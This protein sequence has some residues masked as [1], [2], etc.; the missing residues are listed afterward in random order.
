MSRQPF[1]PVKQ[2]LNRMFPFR[3]VPLP[4][5]LRY[6]SVSPK[7]LNIAREPKAILFYPNIPSKRT[8]MLKICCMNGYRVRNDPTKSF[9]LAV[10]WQDRT[11]RKRDET[12]LN[13]AAKCRVLNIGCCDI[14]KEYVD[15]VFKD[16]FG[17]SA[18]IDPLV[19]EGE[20][21]VKSNLNAKHDGRIEKCPLKAV[22][23][24]V[25][26]QKLINNLCEED[27]IEEIRVPVFGEK[28]PCVYLK[29]RPREERFLVRS[30]KVDMRE[31]QQ[32]FSSEEIEKI[33]LLCQKMGLDYG[34][35]DVLRD[36][37][38]QQLYIVD[39]NNTPFGPPKDLTKSDGRLALRLMAR[40]FEEVFGGAPKGAQW[41]F[42]EVMQSSRYE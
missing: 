17:Y 23:E 10:N 18:M 30:K 31:P 7:V 6:A 28:I 20:C 15:L 22:A 38:T 32:V 37:D 33:I 11:S 42:E 5:R 21:V 27:F 26:Y 19:H 25:V 36:R 2:M 1:R 4:H 14:S 34:E 35:L 12:L 39:V 13:L 16:I 29:Y 8:V 41:A 9:D 24:G 40:T 3:G